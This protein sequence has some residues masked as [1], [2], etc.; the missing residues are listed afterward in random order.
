MSDKLSERDLS[1][2]EFNQLTIEERKQL[3]HQKLRLKRE[4]FHPNMLLMQSNFLNSEIQ[5]IQAS[6]EKHY[7]NKLIDCGSIPQSGKQ[8][9]C[10][11]SLDCKQQLLNYSKCL[12]QF[13]KSAFLC[14]LPKLE[15]VD[16]Y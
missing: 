13:Q 1:D 11:M 15:L 10:L 12:V 8:F 9:V 3:T 5:S 7:F 16:C 4:I 6:Q 2:L 14:K